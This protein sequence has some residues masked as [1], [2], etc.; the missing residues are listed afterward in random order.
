MTETIPTYAAIA[1]HL[2]CIARCQEAGREE[3]LRHWEAQLEK[4]MNDGPSGSGLDHGT[5]L[6]REEC[7][8]NR[9]VFRVDYHHM[10]EVGYYDGWTEHEVIV[11]P[12]FAAG[13]KLR[14]TGRNRNE[15]KDY[16]TTTMHDWLLEQIAR[17]PPSAPGG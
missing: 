17:F 12:D 7:R 6:I 15:I 14:V 16:I 5:I 10:N 11:T 8:K 2:G 13:V 1:E 4:I 9:L 3:W